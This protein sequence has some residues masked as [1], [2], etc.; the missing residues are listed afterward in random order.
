[1]IRKVFQIMI[2]DYTTVDAYWG[3]RRVRDIAEE[4]CLDCFPVLNNGKTVG[5]LTADDLI[6]SHP[7]RIVLDAMSGGYNYIDANKCRVF[8]FRLLPDTG[9]FRTHID[10]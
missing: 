6:K 5:V 2:K 1:M 7:N 8:F 9:Y 3:I 4:T 10:V